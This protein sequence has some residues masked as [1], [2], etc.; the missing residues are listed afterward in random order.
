MHTHRFGRKLKLPSTVA[1]KHG[2]LRTMFQ[3]ELD[4]QALAAKS[5]KVLVAHGRGAAEA[6]NDVETLR[7][8]AAHYT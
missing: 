5:D 7:R 6:P 8:N 1:I 2:I 3:D 4:A